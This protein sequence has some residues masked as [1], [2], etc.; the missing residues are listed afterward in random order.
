MAMSFL[1]MILMFLS[2]SGGFNELLDLT[3]PEAYFKSQGIEYKVDALIGVLEE[4]RTKDVSKLKA[5][6]VKQLLAMRGLGAMKDKEALPAL[7]AA[8]EKKT[9]FFKDYAGEAI[10]SIEGAEYSAPSASADDLKSDLALLPEGVGLVLQART[11]GGGAPELKKIVTE[12]LKGMPDAPAAEEILLN[13]SKE[14][15]G[16]ANQVG[17]FRL[18]AVTLGLS[19]EVND[20]E[21]FVVIIGRGLY[22]HREVE[23]V[24]SGVPRTTHHEIGGTMFLGMDGDDVA[25]AP[26]SKERL[27]MVSGA[28]WESFPLAKVAAKVKAAPSEPKFSEALQKLI[29]RVDRGGSLWGAGILPEA[30]KE[31]EPFAPFDEA[32]MWT[33]ENK[34][35]GKVT[36][37]IDASGTDAKAIAAAMDMMKQGV[38]QGIA[39]IEQ[40]A[41]PGAEML[42]KVMKSIRFSSM[43]LTGTISAEFD[44][45]PGDMIGTI[46]PMFLGVRQAAPIPDQP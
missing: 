40:Q 15:V 8:A 22:D 26:V 33:R 24:L 32:V 30:M 2:S 1:P 44:G 35:T 14:V 11:S 3:E 6:E 10:A 41:P 21:G 36:L 7:K 13:V 25:L 4:P 46:L 45:N 37:K 27:I 18:D 17:N 9:L 38:Q 20:D 23:S 29:A 34:D 19:E 12:A 42:L 28:D 43:N 39:E 31:E 5:Q 16:L